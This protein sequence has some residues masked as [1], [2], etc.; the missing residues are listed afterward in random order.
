MPKTLKYNS[1]LSQKLK[2]ASQG[3]CNCINVMSTSG[4]AACIANP[5]CRGCSDPAGSGFE[6]H[7]F[8]C[9]QEAHAHA[10]GKTALG[11][12]G[13][14]PSPHSCGTNN[15]GDK[16]PGCPSGTSLY[17]PPGGCD[18]SSGGAEEPF[19]N[20]QSCCKQSSGDNNL[21]TE[22][23]C[24]QGGGPGPSPSNLWSCTPRGCIPCPAGS[25]GCQSETECKKTCTI[26]Q[27]YACVVDRE[28]Q[29]RCIS[30]GNLPRKFRIKTLQDCKRMCRNRDNNNNNDYSNINGKCYTGLGGSLSHSQCLNAG[31][32]PGTNQPTNQPS[33]GPSPSPTHKPAADLSDGAIAGIAVGSVAFLVIVIVLLKRI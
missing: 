12:S 1:L 18:C 16:Y 4:L 20:L 19:P 27:P 22:Y 25:L 26:Q 33:K 31:P 23:N 8:E 14:R 2:D 17:N 10:A 28:G 30:A 24:P 6:N 32:A 15:Y 13:H 21:C 9:C 11:C 29:G 5:D 3:G 7:K